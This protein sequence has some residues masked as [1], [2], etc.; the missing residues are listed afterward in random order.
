MS[1]NYNKL[2]RVTELGAKFKDAV[3]KKFGSDRKL[4]AEMMTKIK[5]GE[6]EAVQEKLQAVVEEAMEYA[7]GDKK[8]TGEFIKKNLEI[9]DLTAEFALRVL[10]AEKLAPL[11]PSEL[12]SD[13]NVQFLRDNGAK[14]LAD[15]SAFKPKP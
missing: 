8:P 13:E 11:V 4:A 9:V 5:P 12:K 7:F 15:V 3:E 6:L 2:M 10:P 1:D 14:S